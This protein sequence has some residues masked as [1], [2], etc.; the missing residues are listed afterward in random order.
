MAIFEKPDNVNMVWASDGDKVYPGDEKTP[1]GW[2][3]EI[4]PHENFNY[5]DYKQDAFIAHVNQVGIAEWDEKTQ[6]IGGK[7]VTMGSDGVWYRAIITSINQDPVSAIEGYWEKIHTSLNDATSLKR[8]I[9]YQL[10]ASNITTLVNSRYYL[11]A[12]VTVMLPADHSAGDVVTFAKS[13]TITAIITA[14]APDRIVTS[15]GVYDS[16]TYDFNDE[17][18]FVSNGTNWEV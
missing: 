2:I 18:N 3:E 10:A 7:S 17:I 15:L 16:A 13:P 11:T 4:P 6:Y 1:L 12:P 8:Y 9:G 14:T 5:I